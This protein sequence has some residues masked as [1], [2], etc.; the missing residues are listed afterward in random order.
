MR[1]KEDEPITLNLIKANTQAKDLE[2][3]IP[4][5]D[6]RYKVDGAYSKLYPQ[7][8][9]YNSKKKEQLNGYSPGFIY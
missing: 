5:A 9:T 8:T 3:N 7:Q 2:S 6:L 1:P 4:N